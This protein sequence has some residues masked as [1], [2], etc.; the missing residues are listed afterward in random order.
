[1]TDPL[2]WLRKQIETLDVDVPRMLE[3]RTWTNPAY[4]AEAQKL[5]MYKALLV[6]LDAARGK[7]RKV[8]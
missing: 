3:N 1:M 2:G 4:Q 5:A 8:A 6:E 7:R